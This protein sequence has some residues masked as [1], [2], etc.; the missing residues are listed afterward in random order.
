MKE[1]FSDCNVLYDGYMK[2]GSLGWVEYLKYN[3]DRTWTVWYIPYENDSM[4]VYDESVHGI[5]SLIDYVFE[6]D[7]WLECDDDEIVPLSVKITEE[8]Q[9]Y[10]EHTHPLGLIGPHMNNLLEILDNDRLSDA[11]EL[12]KIAAGIRWIYPD[13]RVDAEKIGL[14][15]LGITRKPIWTRRYKKMF[16]VRTY[17]GN[18]MINPPDKHGCTSLFLDMDQTSH[19][20]DYKPRRL[21]LDTVLMDEL[22]TIQKENCWTSIVLHIPHSSKV[23]P[24]K[25]RDQFLL[26][27]RELE[28]EQLQVV[29][30]YTDELFS[31]PSYSKVLFPVSRLVCD[32]ERFKD[33][34]KEPMAVYGLGAIYTRTVNGEQLRREI[35]TKER[36]ALIKDYYDSHQYEMKRCIEEALLDNG[37]AIVIDCHSFPSKPFSYE[38]DQVSPRP[39]ICIGT[40]VFHTSKKLADLAERYFSTLGYTISMNNPFSGS[41]VPEWYYKR[42]KKVGTIMIEVNRS[43]YMDETTGEKNQNFSKVKEHLQGFPKAF[44][45]YLEKVIMNNMH[46]RK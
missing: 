29:D 37:I 27:D 19:S 18:G 13:E 2:Y 42:N 15:I 32:P 1:D 14:R 46:H 31:N 39:D 6:R 5:G 16:K 7:S 24:S 35:T 36:S 20:F 17:Y 8:E 40:D 45:S 9:A 21:F 22:K 23:I 11:Y 26:S 34:E 4:E 33:D 41:F 10:F 38:Q 12:V 30:H 28:A 3:G 25:Y 43:L 44:Q